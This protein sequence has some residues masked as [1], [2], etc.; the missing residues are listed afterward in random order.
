MA[1]AGDL[2]A[3]P[4]QADHPTAA[5][6]RGLGSYLPQADPLPA[7][8]HCP[9]AAETR[10]RPLAAPIPDHRTGH[11]LPAP[12]RPARATTGPRARSALSPNAPA[13]RRTTSIRA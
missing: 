4:G 10:A 8:V 12:P 6:R 5:A 2:A 11:G 1:S 13:T 9:A 7:A 3:Q